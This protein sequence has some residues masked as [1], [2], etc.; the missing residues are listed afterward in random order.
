MSLARFVPRFIRRHVLVDSRTIYA[1]GVF[2]LCFGGFGL[3]ANLVNMG[4]D[5]EHRC[6]WMLNIN[7]LP[8]DMF[9][10]LPLPRRSVVDKDGSPAWGEH[11][12]WG[13][14]AHFDRDMRNIFFYWGRKVAIWDFPFFNHIHQRHEVQRPDGAWT[15]F[16]GSWEEKHPGDESVTTWNGKPLKDP[17][18][19]HIEELPYRYE[20]RGGDVQTVTATCYIERMAWR[21]KWLTWTRLFEWER[22]SLGITFSD[23]V[24]ERAGSWKGGCTGCGW[25]MLPDETIEQ[26]LRRMEAERKFT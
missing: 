22:R 9:V 5:S 20:L 7:I 26:A 4:E 23:E 8:L 21:P 17:D 1:P 18:G 19:R 16:V 2:E 13:V 25:E 3:G 24:G 12:R 14:M 6:S 15:P 10:Y 11:A